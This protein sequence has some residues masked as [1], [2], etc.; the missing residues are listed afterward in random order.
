MCEI[1]QSPRNRFRKKSEM[2][3]GISYKCLSLHSETKPSMSNLVT[4]DPVTQRQVLIRATDNY[5]KVI[6]RIVAEMGEEIFCTM[7]WEEI[8]QL[9]FYQGFT[10][11]AIA[12]VADDEFRDTVALMVDEIE[13]QKK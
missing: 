7:G 11:G 4:L 5:H 10:N 12:T 3:R 13:Y 2:N 1:T 6:N 9:F 8:A